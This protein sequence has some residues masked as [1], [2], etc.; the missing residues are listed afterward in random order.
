LLHFAT[1]ASTLHFAYRS[2]AHGDLP[3]PISDRADVAGSESVRTEMAE[4]ADA[5]ARS[6]AEACSISERLF[7]E[8][9]PP[10]DLWERAIQRT[11]SGLLEGDDTSIDA[12]KL[13][14]RNFENASRSRK[15]AQ[16]RILP[17]SDAVGSVSIEDAVVAKLDFKKIMSHV[18]P[19]DRELLMLHFMTGRRWAEIAGV[20]ARSH[21]IPQGPNA[22]NRRGNSGVGYTEFINSDLCVFMTAPVENASQIRRTRVGRDSCGMCCRGRCHWHGSQGAGNPRRGTPF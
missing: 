22:R 5:V 4:V 8:P 10:D 12:A 6:W 15:R 21:C 18:H 3:L 1:P 7:S 20:H 11:A 17:M 9:S 14:I 2:R 19:K 13:L 16:V